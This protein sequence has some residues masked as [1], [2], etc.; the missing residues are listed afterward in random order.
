MQNHASSHLILRTGFVALAAALGCGFAQEPRLPDF[1]RRTPVVMAVENVGPAVVSIKTQSKVAARRH[2]F[3]GLF[4]TWDEDS[5]GGYADR[6][7]GSGVVIHPDGFVVTNEHVVA[8]ADRIAV[9]FNLNDAKGDARVLEAELLNSDVDNDLAVLRI[10]APGPF[11]YAKF[12]ATE[13]LMVGETTIA[14]G[15]PF[16]IGASVTTGVLSAKN[17]PVMFK[18]KEVF[19]DFLQTSA[20]IHP[21]N[22]GGPLLDV[23]GYVIG[24]NVAI[25]L[26]GAGIGYAIPADRVQEVVTRLTDPTLVRRAAL[27]IEFGPDAQGVRVAALEKAGPAARAGVVA[28]DVVAAVGG[29]PVKNRLEFNLAA[30]ARFGDG[31]LPLQVRRGDRVENVTVPVE[32][33]PLSALSRRAFPE[34]GFSVADVNAQLAKEFDLDA[35]VGA[36]I[37]AVESGGPADEIELKPGDV[38]YQAGGARVQNADGL[39]QILR[40]YGR[41]GRPLEILV[42]RGGKALRGALTVR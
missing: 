35:A 38:L 4:Q 28:G 6:S 39:A 37:T 13:R 1:D 30:L 24:I 31:K 18:G 23:N 10:V 40:Y 21:G 15:C 42:L 26:R 14:L 12:G 41:R 22:S 32:Q 25:D 8:G 9:Q 34:L 33:A 36:V 16:G 11:P 29:A 27:G 19:R 2:P 20:L 5:V 3:G 17:R 7:V